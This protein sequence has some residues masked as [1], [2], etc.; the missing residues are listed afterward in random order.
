MKLWWKIPCWSDLY[1][2]FRLP[3]IVQGA[4]C[5]GCSRWCP[6]KRELTVF[7]FDFSHTSYKQLDL[8]Q[9]CD[10]A[11][12]AWD[13][14][15]IS[16]ISQVKIKL[17]IKKCVHFVGKK[18]I[19]HVIGIVSALRPGYCANLPAV[20]MIIFAC[21]VWPT[22]G[23]FLIW[24]DFLAWE[25]NLSHIT[26]DI[27]QCILSVKRSLDVALKCFVLLPICDQWY[28]RRAPEC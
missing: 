28:L 15:V 14:W 13:F 25:Y 5:W 8:Q 3:V 26:Y 7:G 20:R 9:M 23:T 21:L 17:I 2:S 22:R 1:M 11:L 27:L 19:K 4:N 24:K 10:C 16:Q 6:S 18:Y 12:L